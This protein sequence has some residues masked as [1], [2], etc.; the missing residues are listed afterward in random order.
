MPAGRQHHDARHTS[1]RTR[2]TLWVVAIFVL[3]QFVAGLGFW[4]FQR[5]SAR[6]IFEGRIEERARRVAMEIAPELRD[7][8]EFRI[9]A[10]ARRELAFI[11]F[12]RFEIEILDSQG[13]SLVHS[14]PRWPPSAS[15]LAARALEADGP[16]R[17]TIPVESV[18]FE[19]PPN[20]RAEAIAVPVRSR[21]GDVAALVVV[22]T[23]AYMRRQATI[24]A[25]ILLVA[26]LIGTLASA[27]SGWFIAGMAVAPILRLSE[28]ATQLTPENI[29]RELVMD[30][31][32]TEIAE[33][34][35]E[36]DAARARI[37]QAFAAQERF[38]SNISHEI[39]TPI[40]ALL[41]E[42]QTLD[43]SNLSKEASDFV[44]SAE[45]EMRKLGKLLESFLTL[46]RV[47]DGSG[48]VRP[49][50]YPANELVMDA[51][52]DCVNTAEQHA[53]RLVPELD[54]TDGGA[55]A[56]FLG[57]PELLRTML[58]NL[59]RNA[60][61]FSPRDGR[62]DVL[63]RAENGLFRV[64]VRDQ[65]PGLPADLLE[66]VFDRFVQSTEELRRER[67]HGLGLAIAKGIAE[68][69]K[70]DVRASNLSPGPGAEFTV[71]I[72]YCR[73]SD[74]PDSTEPNSVGFGGALGGRPLDR[75][76]RTTDT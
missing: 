63:A 44:D 71:W 30:T 74:A 38:L 41:T 73:P 45:D 50:L 35:S 33:L 75:V 28:V 72:P 40:A 6:R 51:V 7:L 13:K 17:G 62:V 66:R 48:V 29:D 26:G 10:I 3:I 76:A 22:T 25:R 2:L 59:I 24:V 68:L 18:D 31:R 21:T 47:R 8:T 43:R 46:T 69:H 70:G 36:L 32:S 61:R 27:I 37:Q 39:K 16:A 20:E 11:Q 60:I 67:G 57:D 5:H 34:T 55:V 1:L 14:E 9:Y 65:G 52:G 56:C 64:T 23:D 15:R 42:A 54:D 19:L 49:R 12:D 4:A 53:V 58:N